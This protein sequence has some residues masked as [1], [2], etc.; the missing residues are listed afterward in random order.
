MSP[1][2]K[3]IR[4]FGGVR[5]LARLMSEAG[6]P[7]SASGVCQWA[8]PVARGGRGGLVPARHHRIL[9]RLAK[10]EGIKLK[11]EDLIDAD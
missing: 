3:V 5:P 7:V 2:T 9:L 10:R 4:A 11:A 1:A 6:H 8:R